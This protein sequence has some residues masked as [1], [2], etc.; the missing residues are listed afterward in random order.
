MGSHDLHYLSTVHDRAHHPASKDPFSVLSL[1]A[2]KNTVLVSHGRPP[3]YG[4]DGKKLCDA[5]VIGIA[6]G[7][8]SGKTHVARQ[9]VRTLGNIPSIVIVSQ[10]SFYKRHTPEEIALAN[11]SM[12]DFDHPDAIDMPMFASCLADLKACKQSNI[13]VYSFSEH[14]RLEETKYLY[15]A[16]I[17][18]AEGIMALHDP[19]L[20]E[21]YDLKV[22]VQ[23]DSD[24]M[25]ARRIAR[26]VKE[27]GR[28]VDG[29]LEQ[30]LRYVK[31]SY[32]NFVRPTAAYAD[33][34][35][36]GSNNSVAIE[37]ITTHIRRQL[38]ERSNRFRA[39]MAIPQRLH[40]P[41]VVTPE[42]KME[43]L[44]LDVLRSTP[45][46]QGIFTILRSADTLR[47]DF[48]FFVDRL[49]TLLVEYAMSLLPHA[50][51]T[52][53]T[54]VGVLSQGKQ[55]DA[56]YVC[57]VCIQRSGGALERG[58]RRVINNVPIG[59]LLVQSALKTGEPTL[60]QVKLPLYI[61]RRDQALETFVFLL[62]A[63]IGTGAAAF[64]AIRILLDHGIRQDHIIFVTFLVARGGGISVLRRAF[65][66]VK[67]VCGAVDDEMEE[68]W[69]DLNNDTVD[70]NPASSGRQVWVM[71][72]GMGQIGIV[73]SAV[74][75]KRRVLMLSYVAGDRYYL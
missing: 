20:R 19:A 54:P 57:G 50:P 40:S 67:I 21:L 45:Q 7:S 43:H 51:K 15:G 24:L 28:S 13:P 3:W 71:R 31:P 44:N 59:S 73:L 9:I 17:I 25:L 42:T 72:P 18:I 16:A 75:K 70:G 2:K 53:M 37:L 74:L 56:K 27:R 58:F 65:P 48:I 62:D 23:C 22:F 34:I 11:A 55:L 36:P 6:G 30:Y 38:Q 26:D 29:I 66:D 64:M 32:D 63:Q 8:A 47:Q 60:L 41:G 35:V 68:G 4:E 5:F 12:F 52:V 39:K 14:Q 1:E 49:S 33:I 61:R 69:L 10:D 46:V